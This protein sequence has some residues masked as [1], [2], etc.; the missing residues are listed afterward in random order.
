MRRFS[1]V[2]CAGVLGWAIVPATAQASRPCAKHERALT[3][4]KTKPAK[5]Q[6]KKALEKCKKAN[7][8]VMMSP[9]NPFVDETVTIAIHPAAPLPHGYIYTYFVDSLGGNLGEGVAKIV[10]KETTSTKAELS[11]T[12][13]F[14][15]KAWAGGKGSVLVTEER[16]GNIATSKIIG[17]LYFR[18]RDR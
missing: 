17:S 5:T 12:E 1:I 18:F 13:D 3:K 14:E 4:A 11:P 10:A 15:D 2:L 7:A 9:A 16:R 6:A 8:P